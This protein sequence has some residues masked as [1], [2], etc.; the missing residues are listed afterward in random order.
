MKI[1]HISAHLGGGVG[2]FIC[3]TFANDG[4]HD[5][6]FVLLEKPI[7]IHLLEDNPVNWLAID[8]L[9]VPLAEYAEQYDIV[10]VEFWN[11]PLLFKFLL[12]NPLPNSRVIA[13]SHVSGLFAPNIIPEAIIEY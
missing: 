13:Y 6:T 7:D 9:T 5:H 10:Q 2:R 4:Q 3:N 1:L 11:H 12:S 8:E